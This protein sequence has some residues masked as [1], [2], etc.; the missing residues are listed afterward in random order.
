M[1]DSLDAI[2][3]QINAGDRQGARLAL[4]EL[5]KTAPDDID[6]WALLAILLSDPAEKAECYRQILRVNPGDRHAAVWLEALE[7]EL[8]RSSANVVPVEE[9]SIGE[10]TRE[11][12]PGMEEPFRPLQGAAVPGL[13]DRTTGQPLDREVDLDLSDDLAGWPEA[14]PRPPGL[15][16]RI[17]G[18]RQRRQPEDRIV[19]S[20]PVEGADAI[21]RGSLNPADILRLAGGPLPPEERRK[22]PDCGAVVSR[23]DSRCPWC[24]AS[25]PHVRQGQ[26]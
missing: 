14:Q 19:V 8:R 10:A 11:P 7:P 6:A 21:P 23:S 18:R 2:K 22:C 4:R 20:P 13:E 26:G 1:M 15:L 12:G 16:E 9:Q 24:S 5:L 17:V 3:Q 25:L